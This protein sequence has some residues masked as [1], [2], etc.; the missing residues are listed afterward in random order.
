MRNTAAR[1]YV[2]ILQG[3]F[4]DK[5]AMSGKGEE[6]AKMFSDI[7]GEWEKGECESDEPSEVLADFR[8][9]AEDGMKITPDYFT[10]RSYLAS[11]ESAALLHIQK[12]GEEL[13]A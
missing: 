4:E 13:S 8:R 3:C 5:A 11:A 10:A 7:R 9:F 2:S 6:Y 1:I 12:I